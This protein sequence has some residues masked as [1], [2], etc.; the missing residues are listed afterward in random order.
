MDDMGSFRIDV[1]I[2]NGATPGVRREVQNVLVDTG[3]ELSCFPANALEDLGIRRTLLRR[4]RQ[5]D[6]TVLERWTGP[7]SIYA[8]GT[9]TVDQVIFGEQGDLVLLG[10]RSLEGLNLRLDPVAK[11]L[12]DA[13]PMPLALFGT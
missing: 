13:G 9:W 1:E 4:F 11:R 12:A 10:S 7:A 2:E 6:G 3:A 5:A 8:V